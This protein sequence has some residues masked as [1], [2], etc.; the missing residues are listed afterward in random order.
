VARLLCGSPTTV[1]PPACITETLG[2]LSSLAVISAFLLVLAFPASRSFA[3]PNRGA[4]DP[5]ATRTRFSR[6]VALP[7][8]ALGAL[9][10]TATLGA[11]AV[12]SIPAW[13]TVL[14]V[15]GLVVAL[16]G[17]VVAATRAE[18]GGRIRRG[19]AA[20]SPPLSAP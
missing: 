4:P 20:P 15:E 19:R 6:E 1:S 10:A 16:S 14:L 17:A 8:V 12:R 5:P 3:V 18:T 9:L 7:S 13:P 11:F 2:S